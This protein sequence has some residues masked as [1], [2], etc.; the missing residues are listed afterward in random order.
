[1]RDCGSDRRVGL[2]LR[3]MRWSEFSSLP[4]REGRGRL[5]AKDKDRM[6]KYP[7]R[8]PRAFSPNA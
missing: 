7:I 1:M 6:C 4:T 3:M 5:G 8:E 2:S